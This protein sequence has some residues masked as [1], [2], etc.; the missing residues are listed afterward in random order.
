MTLRRRLML[1]AVIAVGATVLIGSAITW[2]AMGAELRG[3]VDDALRAQETAIKRQGLAGGPGA[4]GPPP[5]AQIQREQAARG[6]GLTIPAPPRR[7]GGPADY[8]QEIT[9]SGVS[10]SRRGDTERL[11]VTGADLAVARGQSSEVLDDRDRDDGEHVRVLTFPARDRGHAFMVARS[12][13]STDRVMSRMALVLLLV[14]AGA[15]LASLGAAW[16]LARGV[17]RPISDLTQATDHIEAT[18]DLSRRVPVSGDDEVGRLAR[19]FN[20]M[21]DRLGISIAAQRQL[22]AD[23]SHELRTPVTAL[24]TNAEVLSGSPRLGAEE[25]QAILDDI[26]MQTEELTDIVSDV[27][28]LARGDADLDAPHVTDDVAFGDLVTESVERARRHSPDATF[29][30]KIEPVVV[31]GDAQRLARAVNN[32]LDNAAK[33]SGKGTIGVTLAADGT[34]TVRDRGPG[35]AEDELPRVFERFYRGASAR[36]H[37]GSGLGLAIVKQV[38]ESHGGTVE[39]ANAS[40]GGGAIAR[41]RLPTV[42]G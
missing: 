38:A 1:M 41:L 2:F 15:T 32:L 17:L 37:H 12:L 21:L 22:V 20:A 9:A 7:Q 29:E 25:R 30:T 6:A 34:L 24:R 33:Y 13:E 3:E 4:P 40:G 42:S 8:V 11:P 35:I 10:Q 39:L 14:C 19:G 26:V 27:I 23:V 18:G 16:L 31:S 36:E 28:E 5:P